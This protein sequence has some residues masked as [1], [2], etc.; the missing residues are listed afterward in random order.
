MMT[1]CVSTLILA[2]LAFYAFWGDALGAGHVFNPFGFLFLFFA[3]VVWF[4][5]EIVRAAFRSVKYE[6]NLPII[7]MGYKVF[8]GFGA[9]TRRDDLPAE[10][11]SGRR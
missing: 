11:S 9:K 7:R 3:I 8:Q 10:R 2:A 5:W 4:K 6:S 1:R